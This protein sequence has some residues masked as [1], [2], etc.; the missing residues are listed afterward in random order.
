MSESKQSREKQGGTSETHIVMFVH[1]K[2]YIFSQVENCI[3]QEERDSKRLIQR[4]PILHEDRLKMIPSEDESYL[5]FN[6]RNFIYQWDLDTTQIK[7]K[8]QINSRLSPFSIANFF[9]DTATKHLVVHNGYAVQIWD[10]FNKVRLR[11]LKLPGPYTYVCTSAQSVFYQSDPAFDRVIRWNYGTNETTECFRLPGAYLFCTSRCGQYLFVATYSSILIVWDLRTY[12]SI[13]TMP[14]DATATELYTS[15]DDQYLFSVHFSTI[16]QWNWQQRTCVQQLILNHPIRLFIHP[17]NFCVFIIHGS[18][19]G[20][21]EKHWHAWCFRCTTFG[22]HNSNPKWNRALCDLYY[23]HYCLND[24]LRHSYNRLQCA[25]KQCDPFPS[26]NIRQDP[27]CRQ[28]LQ[29]QQEKVQVVL[30]EVLSGIVVDYT[31]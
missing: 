4:I 21:S 15:I 24:S 8:F 9:I 27:L 18:A 2:T 30:P 17:N 28:L 7:Q 22:E 12:E 23:E 1:S 19:L 11:Q 3:T 6:Q 26:E 5:F 13:V 29:M 20:S 10:I 31:L 14:F 16:K 25:I